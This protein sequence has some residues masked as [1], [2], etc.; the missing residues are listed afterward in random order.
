MPSRVLPEALE[1]WR[2]SE[3]LLGSLSPVDSDYESAR[4]LVVQLRDLYAWI[5]SRESLSDAEFESV[6]GALSRATVAVADI[7][8]RQTIGSGPPPEVELSPG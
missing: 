3:R 2:A 4:G 7:G 8:H 6:Q 5:S 1:V